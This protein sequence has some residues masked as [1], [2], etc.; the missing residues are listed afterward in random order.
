VFLEPEEGS[1]LIARYLYMRSGT[2]VGT[3]HAG[4]AVDV[5]VAN[6]HDNEDNPRLY[7]AMGCLTLVDPRKRTEIVCASKLCDYVLDM[8]SGDFNAAVGSEPVS[9]RS[10]EEVAWEWVEKVGLS[11]E[12]PPHVKSMPGA[13]KKMLRDLQM[14]PRQLPA[15][16]SGAHLEDHVKNVVAQTLVLPDERDNVAIQTLS[17]ALHTA[18][19]HLDA[20]LPAL[21]QELVRE[22]SL[23]LVGVIYEAAKGR[24]EELSSVISGGNVSGARKFLR[25]LA[26]EETGYLTTTNAQYRAAVAGAESAL[27]NTIEKMQHS[28]GELLRIAQTR[29]NG[30]GHR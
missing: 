15:L 18:V 8:I 3:S 29:V 23:T 11:F 6:W 17:A 21:V 7:S 13:E 1:R 22:R 20:T 19:G 14:S 4:R 26:D 9:K 5:N 12:P 30:R 16:P 2:L 28:R 25:L 27:R 24:A 10:M